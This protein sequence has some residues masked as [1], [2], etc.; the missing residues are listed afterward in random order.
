MDTLAFSSSISVQVSKRHYQIL[1]SERWLG[2]ELYQAMLASFAFDL[3][4]AD[5]STAPPQSS[6]ST[7]TPATP[8]QHDCASSSGDSKAK[9]LC[10]P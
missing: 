2:S 7:I 6:S 10:A 3:A 9:P 8:V 5:Q 1:A 4:G